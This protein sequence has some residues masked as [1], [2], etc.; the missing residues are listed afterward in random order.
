M[1]LRSLDRLED[2]L[3]AYGDVENRF[4][5]YVPTYLMAGQVATALDRPEV[6]RKWLEKG[7]DVARRAG[8]SKTLS[9]LQDALDT[10][11]K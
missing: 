3:A 11:S 5:D 4:P 8:D 10:L 2:A 7:V 9:E 1:E 6:A